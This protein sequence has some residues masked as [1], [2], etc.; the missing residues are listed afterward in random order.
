MYIHVSEC[1]LKLISHY[2]TAVVIFNILCDLTV[3][4]HMIKLVCSEDTV[5]KATQKPAIHEELIQQQFYD[6]CTKFPS[7]TE[8]HLNHSLHHCESTF[9]SPLLFSYFLDVFHSASLSL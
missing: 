5:Y 3:Y 1:T 4:P 2:C 6:F 8:N 9:R 7:L